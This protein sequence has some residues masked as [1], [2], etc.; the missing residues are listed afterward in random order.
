M[1]HK[2]SDQ[3]VHKLMT[4]DRI[5][6]LPVS[7]NSYSTPKGADGGGFMKGFIFLTQHERGKYTHRY[8]FIEEY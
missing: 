2:N 1:K 8:L 4:I 5:T 3:R 7:N 6:C